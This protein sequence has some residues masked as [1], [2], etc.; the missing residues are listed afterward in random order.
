MSQ[1]LSDLDLDAMRLGAGAAE[2]VDHLQ[3]CE[4]CQARQHTLTREAED[5][6]QRFN[7][8]GLA[9]QTLA[10]SPRP[11]PWWRRLAWASAPLAAMAAL[12]L[13]VVMPSE[14]ELRTKGGPSPVEVF[15][16]TEQGPKPM[17]ATV[18]PG[19]R[20]AVRNNPGE[21]RQVRLL[22]GL[23]RG[24]WQ[25]LYPDDAAPSWQTKGPAWL[26]QEVVLDGETAPERLQVVM[27]RQPV[28]HSQALALIGNVAQAGCALHSVDVVKQ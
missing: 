27:C 24:P 10:Q 25:A 9:A 7:P 4:T 15:V 16:V 13:M 20:L 6:A 19:A 17:P 5:F 1:H 3:G 8:A 18:A 2:A 26:S 22:W 12:L 28:S 11:R 21:T 14:T 23:K